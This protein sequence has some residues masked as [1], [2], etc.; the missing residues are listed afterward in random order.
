MEQKIVLSEKRKGEIAYAMLF[1]SLKRS[2]HMLTRTEILKKIGKFSVILKKLQI[3]KEEIMLLYQEIIC[4]LVQS[5]FG[6]KY[7][8]E[9]GLNKE[10]PLS[11]E[12]KGE[13]ALQVWKINIREKSLS[14]EKNDFDRRIGNVMQSLSEYQISKEEV[15]ALY[16]E[17]VQ[18]AIQELFP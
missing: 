15:M 2:Q 13:I 16:Y 3:G 10:L 7:F 5:S 18:E 11:P 9:T 17:L 1:E 14:L 8:Y 6:P 12:R 4:K